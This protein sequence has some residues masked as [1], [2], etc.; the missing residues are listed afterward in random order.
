MGGY[1]DS[2]YVCKNLQQLSRNP[3]SPTVAVPLLL[4]SPLLA[5]VREHVRDQLATGDRVTDPS[6]D[7]G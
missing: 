3:R 4:V 1:L 2:L 6:N 7:E 5:A